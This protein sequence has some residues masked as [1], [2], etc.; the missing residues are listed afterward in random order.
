M[1][2][3]RL[4]VTVSF[5]VIIWNVPFRAVMFAP[6]SVSF[7]TSSVI[8]TISSK[9]ALVELALL[10]DNIKFV[11]DGAIVSIIIHHTVLDPVCIAGLLYLKLQIM[12]QDRNVQD[13]V[14]CNT[15]C[16]VECCI[17]CRM[18]CRDRKIDCNCVVF[19]YHLEC[20]I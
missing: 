2:T 1:Q 8:V 9:V 18:I 16:N 10:L 20:S 3:G 13:I 12:N 5:S 7:V 11:I 15:C 19:S 4:I 17:A 14:L 6:A